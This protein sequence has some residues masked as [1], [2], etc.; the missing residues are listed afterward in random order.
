MNSDD[1]S[2]KI[3]VNED[4]FGNVRPTWTYDWLGQFDG[5]EIELKPTLKYSTVPSSVP[6]F[7]EPKKKQVCRNWFVICRSL[8]LTTPT[9]KQGQPSATLHWNLSSTT[10][11]TSQARVTTL[12]TAPLK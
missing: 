10:P 5:G 2:Q 1:W 6:M 8:L 7:Q 3:F 12:T 4:N 9:V 11:A